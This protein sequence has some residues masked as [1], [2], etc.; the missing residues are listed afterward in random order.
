MSA[1]LAWASFMVEV[2]A[3][4]S[5]RSPVWST[6]PG[7][8]REACAHLTYLRKTTLS[9]N[10]AN[11]PRL[12]DGGLLREFGWQRPLLERVAMVEVQVQLYSILREKLPPEARGRTLMRLD[13]KATLDELLQ[14]LDIKRR[15][16][17]S[18][19]GKHEPDSSRPLR[20]NDEVKIFSSVSGGQ[21][22]L[23]ALAC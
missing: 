3:W 20:D 12:P 11:N 2:Q 10:L 5:S 23:D 18:V 19:N 22:C 6:T 15:V 8:G 21:L 13:E 16:V 9:G 7:R 17:I 14:K 1:Q 4:T